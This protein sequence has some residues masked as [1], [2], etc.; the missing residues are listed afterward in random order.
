[1]PRDYSKGKIYLMKCLLTHELYVGSTTSTLVKRQQ[2]HYN[3]KNCLFSKRINDIGKEHF[4]ME[5]IENWPCDNNEQLLKREG[6]NQVLYN[7]VRNGLNAMYANTLKFVNDL[8]LKKYREEN[9]EARIVYLQE[10]RK[11]NKDILNEKKRIKRQGKDREKVLQQQKES[12]ERNKETLNE[13]IECECG[14]K[15]SR[16]DKSRHL[17]TIIHINYLESKK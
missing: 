2:Q 6:Y 4:T 8:K 3:T 14:G 13:K 12:Y 7:T 9:K 11:K 1:M 17:K 15:Y 16:K 10:Y 5:L